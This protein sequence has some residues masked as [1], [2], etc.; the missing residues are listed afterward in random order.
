[1]AHKKAGG[2]SR[3]GRDSESK[4]L[5]V[6]RYGGQLV[7]AGSI[8]VRQRGTQFHPGDNVGLGKDHTLFAKVNG[9]VE[10]VTKGAER[11]KTVRIVP[12][13]A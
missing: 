3:N 8:I 5:G 13:V 7:S 9:K 12:A 10:F 2:S 1:M 11:R 4:R 6:K